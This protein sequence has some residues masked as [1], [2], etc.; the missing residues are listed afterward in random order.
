[1]ILCEDGLCQIQFCPKTFLLRSIK[2]CKITHNIFLLHFDKKEMRYFV[3]V[4]F[5]EEFEM[6]LKLTLITMFNRLLAILF[7]TI[8][9]NGCDDGDVILSNFN[10]ENA[11][12]KTCGDVGNYVFYKENPQ[13]F[14]S[15]SLRLGTTD[16]IYNTEG[17][18]IYELGSNTNF[19]NYRS[20]DGALGSNY[21]CNSVPPTSP[22]V[23]ADYLGV[24]GTAK[25]IVKFKWDNPKNKEWQGE[26][27]LSHT[28]H[29][30][31]G[32]NHNPKQRNTLRKSVQVILKNVVLINGDK[33]IIQESIDMGTIENVRTEEINP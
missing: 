8:L 6:K 15:L 17:E 33:Q 21:F 4:K 29:K 12:L 10:F 26:A 32:S 2:V 20:Y 11:E 19:V 25:V 18:K 9:F 22:K 31:R 27:S 23:I 30:N 13:V 7:L 28:K 1:M 5:C 3:F 24:S 14:E 16:S